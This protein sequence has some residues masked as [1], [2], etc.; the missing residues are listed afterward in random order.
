MPPR[1]GFSVDPRQALSEEDELRVVRQGAQMGYTSAWTPAGP[2]AAAFDRCLRWHR[3]T[4]LPTGISVVPASGQPPAF[5]A[6]QARRVWEETGGSF[7]LGVGSGHMPQAAT[8][9]RDYLAELRRL[10]PEGLPVYL[11]ALGP[12]MLRLAGECAEGVLLNWC[13]AAQAV[14]SR[15]LVEKAARAAGRTTPVIASYIRTSV[16]P[17]PALA[18]ATL[19]AAALQYALGPPAYRSHFER[20]GFAGELR[21]LEQQG[22]EPSPEFLA[23]AGAAGAPGEVREHFER[24]A[25]PL[26]L[27]IV[28][29]LVTRSGD[30]ESA[31]LTLNEVSLPPAGRD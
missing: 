4:G 18:R 14:W 25:A 20:M 7:V 27:A 9:M 15:G 16:D 8:G 30:A 24:L 13:S 26:D 19:A 3:A 5:Y 23:A 28:R 29:V 11:A 1:L 6:Q 21:R 10:L 22:G 31:L 12:R 17:D 2:D